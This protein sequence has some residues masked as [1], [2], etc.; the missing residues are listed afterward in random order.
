[1]RYN[2]TPLYVCCVESNSTQYT[3]YQPRDTDFIRRYRNDAVLFYVCSELRCT[4]TTYNIT[5]LGSST[6]TD[7]L[8]QGTAL[9]RMFEG[10]A[11]GEP[12]Q[13]NQVR[14]SRNNTV[15]KT[16]SSEV[17]I[18]VAENSAEHTAVSIGLPPV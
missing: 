14:L 17:D 3:E 11:C 8:Q 13:A 5:R 10:G 6:N 18:S 7:T 12:F 15:K 9:S 16:N 2:S 4:Q 1:M